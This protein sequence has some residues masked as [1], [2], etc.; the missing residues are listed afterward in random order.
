MIPLLLT[1]LPALQDKPAAPSSEWKNL[2][3]I[4][5][6]INDETVTER[7]FL[8]QLAR[9]R[10]ANPGGDPKAA[11]EALQREIVLDA[12]GSQAGEAMGFDQA[13]VR[14]SVREWERA[15]IDNAGGA[16][17]YALK[18]A[19]ENRTAEDVRRDL[20]KRVL[21]RY[22]EESCTG[23]GPNQQGKIVADR[24]VRPGILRLSYQQI[25][26]DPRRV[27]SIGGSP[28]KVVLQILEVDPAKVGGT[29]QVQAAAAAIRAR[30][31]SGASD[32]ESEARQYALPSS[33]STPREP[34]DEAGLANEYPGLAKLVAQA[35]DGDLLPLVA[36]NGSKQEWSIVR[37][38]QRSS[39]V[40]P[41]FR[42]PG[43]QQKIREDRQQQLDE[44]RLGIARLKQYE[45]SYIWPPRASGR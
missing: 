23:K 15:L 37:L 6:I 19:N 40:V 38:V 10:Q 32:F 8:V 18:L 39:A 31:A 2:D 20:E 34:I 21:R 41:D 28:S 30:L 13:R 16:V 12:V 43:L 25:V 14:G 11:S 42:T 24:F 33:S 45:G 44:Q 4:A 27:E 36:P 3:G 5:L 9:F 35:R 22:W 7:G 26:N 29:S 17:P 1:L